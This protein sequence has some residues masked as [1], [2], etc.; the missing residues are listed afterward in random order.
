M[1]ANLRVVKTRVGAVAARYPVGA[2]AADN[3]RDSS[4]ES[5]EEAA[6]PRKKTDAELKVGALCKRAI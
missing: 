6:T 2:K 4:S 3:D 1:S 5:S